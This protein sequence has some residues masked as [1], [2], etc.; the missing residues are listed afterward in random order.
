MIYSNLK[1][2]ALLKV[3]RVR[4]SKAFLM[5]YCCF[6]S[7]PSLGKFVKTILFFLAPT[8]VPPSLHHPAL[9]NRKIPGKT[10]FFLNI[11]WDRASK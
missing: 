9:Q 8:H 1:A 3:N 7:F 4:G 6:N 5:Y 2:G 11:F 10:V